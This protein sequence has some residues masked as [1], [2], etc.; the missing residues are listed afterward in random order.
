MTGNFSWGRNGSF[1]RPVEEKAFGVGATLTERAIVATSTKDSASLSRQSGWSLPVADKTEGR[2]ILVYC[3]PAP[4]WN[5]NFWEAVAVGLWQVWGQPG[6]QGK[7][8]F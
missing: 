2:Q 7:T 6:L 3:H 8:L 5:L 4:T 1:A